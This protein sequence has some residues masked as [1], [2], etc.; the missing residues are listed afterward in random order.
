MLRPG[1]T[2]S[3]DA[4]DGLLKPIVERYRNRDIQRFF[5]GDAAF[6]K[7]EIYHFL[8][9]EHYLYAI[10]LPANEVLYREVE[11]L[12]KSPAVWPGKRHAVRYKSFRYR[13][14]SWPLTGT[15][16]G[17]GWQ[18]ERRVVAKV[19]WHLDELFPR[20]GFIVTNLRWWSKNVVGFYNQR[21][22]AK[23]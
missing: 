16:A 5:R 9:N 15:T 23:Q 6:A 22:T 21:G 10:R 11:E 8:E 7:P 14:G 3:A 18:K 1:N 12:T 4:W 13:A 20:V 19:E 2:H 17:K